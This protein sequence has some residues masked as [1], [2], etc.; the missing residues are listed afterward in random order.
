MSWILSFHFIDLTIFSESF[1]LKI[2]N[3]RYYLFIEYLVCTEQCAKLFPHVF[4]PK[5]T[6]CGRG[7]YFSSF[8][9]EVA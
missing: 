8:T 6:I 7:H 5:M 2:I 1:H 9:D 3:N 4:Y